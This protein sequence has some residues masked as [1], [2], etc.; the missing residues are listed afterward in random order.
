M[1]GLIFWALFLFVYFGFSLWLAK[2]ILV[3]IFHAVSREGAEQPVASLAV[4]TSESHLDH[5]LE[6]LKR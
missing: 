5:T 1:M 2:G 3:A 6:L 4:E